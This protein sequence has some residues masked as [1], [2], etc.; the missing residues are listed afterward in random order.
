MSDS[1]REANVRLK[2]SIDESALKQVDKAGADLDARL[3]SITKSA[4]A[5]GDAADRSGQALRDS[6]AS[7][8]RSA[9]KL[10]DAIAKAKD[11]AER[12]A[13]TK[14]GSFNDLRGDLLGGSPA[15]PGS[16]GSGV[17]VESLR[18][19]GG[20]L[21]QLGLGDVGGAITRAGD[22]GQVGKEVKAIT[23]QFGALGGQLQGMGG[24]IG[25]VAADGAAAAGGLGATAAGMGAVIAVAAPVVVVLGAIALGLKLLSDGAAD[26]KKNLEAAL[27]SQKGYYEFAA[28]AS[29][30]EAQA[31]VASLQSTREAQLKAAN[32]TEGALKQ[33]EQALH[34]TRDVGIALPRE[35]GDGFRILT[36]Q[37]DENKKSILDTD[38]ALGRLGGGLASGAFAA[39]QAAIDLKRSGEAQL[40]MAAFARTASTEQLQA[41]ITE[42]AETI[43]TTEAL[44]AQAQAQAA[45][46]PESAKAADLV[47]EYSG[48]LVDLRAT[49][50]ALTGDTGRL[51]AAREAERNAVKGIE[52]AIKHEIDFNKLR[53]TAS[54]EQIQGQIADLKAE[55][56][57]RQKH[58]AELQARAEKEGPDGSAA[59]ALKENQD[60]VKEIDR[61]LG[62]LTGTVLDQAKANDEQKKAAEGAKKAASDYAQSLE[63]TDE[64]TKRAARAQ[65]DFND[66]TARIARDR[67]R[68]DLREGQDLARRNTREGRALAL[69]E[70][71]EAEDI[72]R[73]R[74]KRLADIL[75]ES[76]NAEVEAQKQEAKDAAKFRQDQQ[77]ATAD[78]YDKLADI[79]RNR[80]DAVFDA[81]TNLDATAVFRAQRDALRSTDAENRDFGKTQGRAAEDQQQREQEAAQQ[82]AVERENRLKAFQEQLADEDAQRA[83][84]QARRAEDRAIK[85]QEESE[86]RAITK[87]RRDEDRAIQDA[88]RKASRDK[89]IADE[90]DALK[91]ESDIRKKALTAAT[92]DEESFWKGFGDDASA[93]LDQARQALARFKNDA[94]SVGSG[95]SQASAGSQ[96]AG[97]AVTPSQ[98]VIVQTKTVTTYQRRNLLDG[99]AEGGDPPLGRPVLVGEGGPE[100]VQFDRPARV[101]PADQTLSALSALGRQAGGRS[102]QIGSLSVPVTVT[103]N[104]GGITPAQIQQAVVDALYQAIPETIGGVN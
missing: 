50:N 22:I 78:H 1:N 76:G 60:R 65:R 66:E 88:D 43:K 47:V 61:D 16:G 89:Q 77:R 6:F 10:G 85:V 63:R 4:G 14:P 39:N 27:G 3:K 98:R 79:E 52:D 5:L 87:A 8:E 95:G 29:T 12:L 86:D 101:I 58:Q 93:A 15:A 35:L 92:K 36:K 54:A 30:E 11:K 99:F 80:L 9:S 37:L 2:Y 48:R 31:R 13:K 72:T 42:N 96:S 56:D 70:R 74:A 68:G 91:K 32:E 38:S 7:S 94:A 59:K 46:H 21:S 53:R 55:R 75:K 71:R 90:Q 97:K 34:V 83:I 40:Q 82:R 64:I 24:I 57:A 33:L 73:D 41:R 45:A 100:M 23:D 67:A 62:E 25:T 20:A 102:V 104:A 18:R 103:G 81:A 49:Q 26:G 69:S 19:T 84:A 51:I 44:L 28:T 17:G